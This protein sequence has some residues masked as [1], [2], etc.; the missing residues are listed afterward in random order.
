[1]TNVRKSKERIEK[2]SIAAGAETKVS[3]F[4]ENASFMIFSFFPFCRDV[5]LTL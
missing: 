5:R 2:Q 1:M 3:F 4:V